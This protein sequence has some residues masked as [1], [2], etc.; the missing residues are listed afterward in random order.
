MP[1]SQLHCKRLATE[2]GR[3]SHGQHYVKEKRLGILHLLCE[4]NSIRSTS[5]LT[6]STIRTI[7]RQLTIAGE[8]CR[9][10]M[11]ENMRN[12]KL[13]QLQ[14]D[15][16]WTYVHCKEGNRETA[17]MK[18]PTFGDAYLFV[19]LDRES[20]LVPC[21]TLGKRTKETT[22][23]FIKDLAQR[24]EFPHDPNV[25]W[26]EKPQLST[27]GWQSYPNAIFDSFGSRVA[28][29][30]IIKSYENHEQPG[31]YGPPDVVKIERRGIRGIMN[32][33]TICTS[34]VERN[35]LT[36]RT[37]IRRFTRLTLA[38][39]KKFENLWAAINLHVAYY[40]FCRIHG[41][42]KRTPAMAAGVTDTLWSL[43]DLMEGG[44]R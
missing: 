37:F 1:S 42:L 26:D 31:R 3:A 41:S 19:A 30:Q 11:D 34:H 4:G 14:L 6:G 24:I 20:K 9:E 7:L 28:H 43:E 2:N 29:G 32:L 21:C 35:N 27:D 18:H 23:L 44:A 39:S 17:K 13:N 36:L 15:E 40:N 12:L 38:F 16:I 5:R 25:P 10:V 22:E 33:F 8:R